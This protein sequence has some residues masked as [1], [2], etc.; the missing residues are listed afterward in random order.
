MRGGQVLA[1]RGNRPA[2]VTRH[3]APEA[4]VRFGAKGDIVAM[5]IYVRLPPKADIG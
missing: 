5:L 3:K 2:R 1:Q 4:N